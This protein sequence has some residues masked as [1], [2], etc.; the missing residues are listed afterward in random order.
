[1]PTHVLHLYDTLLRRVEPILPSDGKKIRMYTC[2]PTIYDNAH[3]GNFRTFLFEDLLRRTLKLFGYQVCQVMNLTDV[4]DK[5]IKGATQK[6]IPLKQYTDQYKEAFFQDLDA[7]RIE[8]AEHYPE[9]TA[10]IP[11]MIAMIQ[12]LERKGAAYKDA[13]GSVYFD[14]SKAKEYGKLSHL[15]LGSL[16]HG[17]SKK[18][19]GDEYAGEGAADFVL[20]KA[21][22]PQR[23]GAVFWESPWGKGRPGWHLECSVMAKKL[24]GETIDVHA[25]GVDLI[26][27]HHENEIA[28]SETCTGKPFALHWVH[29]EHLLVDHKKMSKSLGNFYTLRDLLAKGHSPVAIRFFLQ[30]NHYRTQFNFSFQALE[31]AAA[32]VKRVRDFAERV[33]GTGTEQ[34]VSPSVKEAID[35]YENR[36]CTALA[37]DLNINEGLSALFEFIRYGNH[38]LDTEA[39]TEGDRQYA[40]AFLQKADSIVAIVEPEKEE[41]PLSVVQLLNERLGARKRKEWAKSDALRAQITALGYIVEDLPEGQRTSKGGPCTPKN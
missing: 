26:F 6:G 36:F 3:I 33:K 30:G 17:A 41:L 23:D 4:D 11:D 15:D 39:M 35:G 1:M 7:L 5:T 13:D 28:Q 20:W 8:R 25:G 14:L 22:D 19:L 16:Q 40:R 32:G 12:E 34:P 31:A 9:A 29:A 38:L 10:Y 37:N 27:P 2:G 18:T 24:L 21:Y